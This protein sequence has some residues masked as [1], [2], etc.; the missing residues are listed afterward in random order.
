MDV[1]AVIR[2][3]AQVWAAGD[4]AVRS[5]ATADLVTVVAGVGGGYV[6][7]AGTVAVTVL[8]AHT[9]ASTGNRV[10]LRADGNVLLDARDKTG[11]VVM[12]ASIAGGFV[13]VGATVG[14]AVIDRDTQARVGDNSKVDGRALSGKGFLAGVLDGTYTDSAG[15]GSFTEFRGVAIQASSDL[16][17]TGVTASVGGGF[18]GVAGSVNVTTITVL[19]KAAIGAGVRVNENSAGTTV[20]GQ[21]VS[22]TAV[23]SSE[24]FALAGSV[25]GG[26]VGVGGGVNVGVLKVTV[27]SGTGG[28][29]VVKAKGN[30]GVHA[31]SAK[32]VTT[33]ALSV[34]G[35]FVGVAGSV[36]VW[37]IGTESTTTYDDGGEGPDRGSWSSTTTY[38]R[39][40]VVTFS[41][42]RYAAKEDSL[43]GGSDPSLN[44]A[45]WQGVQQNPMA[46]DQGNAVSDTDV[47]VSGQDGG[48]DRGAWTSASSYARN[49]VVTHNG[50][51]YVATRVI[52]AG[53]S[54][55]DT[56]GSG[57]VK[58]SGGY[59]TALK[60]T[61]GSTSTTWSPIVQYRKNDIV[62]VMV[63]GK[64][65]YYIALAD[66]YGADPLTSPALWARTSGADAATNGRIAAG[67]SLATAGIT[68][69]TPS[70][71]V[72]T[73][74]SGSGQPDGT[75]VLVAGTLEAGGGISV[76]AIE[77][78]EVYGLA[79]SV[80]GGVV[81]VGA[82]VL[83]LNV[84]SVTDA[85]VSGTGRLSAGGAISVNARTD[86]DMYALAAGG[87]GGVVGV[88]AQ[89]AVL[90]DDTR[91]RAHIDT[92]AQI[93]RAGGG[94]SIAATAVR[95]V[96][97]LVVVGTV[98]AGAAGAAV[99]VVEA[100][101]DTRAEIGN[102]AMGTDVVGNTG[103]VSGVSVAANA[104]VAPTATAYSA[105]LGGLALSGAVA[106]S[107]L[108]GV[109]R[110]ASGAHGPTGSGGVSVTATGTHDGVR[111]DSF[112]AAV[113]GV[114]GGLT[115][116][117]AIDDRSTEAE[118]TSTAGGTSSGSVNVTATA[119]NVAQAFAPSVSVGGVSLA[120]M[121]PTSR[122]S[123]HTS[124]RIAG[125]VA[126]STGIT[127]NAT[128]ANRATADAKIGSVAI[129]GLSG[130]FSTAEITSGAYI[131][132]SV[133]SASSLASSGALAVSA[134]TKT[135]DAT[136]A[137]AATATVGALSIGVISAGVMASDARVAG[138]VK[139][140]LDGTVTSS[141]GITVTATGGNTADA[142]NQVLSAGLFTGSGSMVRALV[143]STADVEA[144]SSSTTESLT[145][146]GAVS[147]T[148]TSSNRA[149][150]YTQ[151]AS[152]GLASLGVSVPTA[153]VGGGT[154][155]ALAASV[156]TSSGG[157]VVQATSRNLADADALTVAAGAFLG[158][159]FTKAD[160][161]VTADA[162]TD[163]LVAQSANITATGQTVL[164]SATSHNEANADTQQ[165]SAGAFSISGMATTARV[166]GA[167]TA[168]LAGDIHASESVT[169]RSRA[170]NVADSESFV[171]GVGLASGV[172]SY[173]AAE[174][175]AGAVTT[176]RTTSPS[177]VTST[178]AVLV[179]SAL[180]LD[181]NGDG[182][183]A[184]AKTYGASG[185]V[186][187]GAVLVTDAVV[188]APVR[189]TMDGDATAASTT[190]KA[191]G[192]N[193]AQA[194]TESLNIGAVSL[195][196]AGGNA[197]IASTA[198]VDATIGPLALLTLT[199][200]ARV[201]ATGGNKAVAVS[202]GATGGL[203]AAGVNLPQ[204]VVR[205]GVLAV[206]DGT[207]VGANLVNVTAVGVNKATAS[208]DLVAA[209]LF[210]GGGA[211]PS[212]V[213]GDDPATPAADEA[214]TVARLGGTGV[215]SSPAGTFTISAT[216]T[217]STVAT[218]G[219][220]T[221]GVVAVDVSQPTA[222]ASG[223]TR[224]QLF[225][226]VRTGSGPAA[227]AGATTVSVLASGTDTA[228]AS[229]R[230]V[231]GGV[232]R[233]GS[234]ASSAVVGSLVDVVVGRTGGST[235]IASDDIVVKA[236][237]T[238]DADS[239]THSAGGGAVNI[240]GF[241]SSASANPIVTTTLNSGTLLRAADQVT[242][243]AAHNE[244]Q[245]VMSDGTFDAGAA[246]DDV[247]DTIT[248]VNPHGLVT[249]SQVVYDA[250]G[251][252]N[253]GTYVTTG[254]SYTVIVPEGSTRTVLL[255]AAF[256]GSSYD[257]DGD[258]IVFPGAH[259]LRTDDMVVY[260]LGAGATATAGLV[261]GRSYRVRV[262]DS[263]RIRLLD[264]TDTALMAAFNAPLSVAATSIS[265]THV[266]VANS[267]Y[268]GAAVTYYAPPPVATFGSALVDA[269][270]TTL[271][272]N[273]VPERSGDSIVPQD[274]NRIYLAQHGLNTG[275]AVVY[276]AADPARRLTSAGVSLTQGGLFWVYRNNADQIQLATSYCNAVGPDDDACDLPDGGDAGTEPDPHPRVLMPLESVG[277][278]QHTLT[279]YQDQPLTDL[280]SGR[281]YFVV[282][283]DPST[284]F[285]RLAE[286]A[287]G[288]GL[289]LDTLGLTGG[290]H[291]FVVEGMNLTSTAGTG[292]QRLVLDIAPRSGVQQLVLGGL[293]N[294]I[295]APTGDRVV[296]ASSSGGGG[297]AINVT[298]ATATAKNTPTVRVD[299]SATVA[300]RDI[301]V[302]SNNVALV[303]AS[304]TNGGGG[305]ISVGDA[306]AFSYVNGSS[307]VNILSGAQLTGT[308]SVVIDGRSD[309]TASSAAETDSVGLGSGVD[310]DTA[311]TLNY[312]TVVT[313]DGTVTA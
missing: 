197:T 255:G 220:V 308:F 33:Y 214:E 50:V 235:V 187:S 136:S 134:T 196:G 96:D 306:D 102:V 154:K 271:N 126:G 244:L 274:N 169:V 206:L 212:A 13:G 38:N 18:V 299:V 27:Q 167:T 75:S 232:V 262:V 242:V 24:V 241:T 226:D 143:S 41:G 77:D 257:A 195:S 239:K 288:A 132:A 293:A 280:V 83:V 74:L 178:G 302:T 238:T 37:T 86:S 121:L 157:V 124:A 44:T 297:G 213:V 88:S 256:D 243:A 173:A 199:G 236:L 122:V 146:S 29:S 221:G 210:A 266:N 94:V 229:L 188:R 95:D 149:N 287:G 181:G 227:T 138:A 92:G 26:F 272:G 11:S 80:A 25:A 207:V 4:I 305:L 7:V 51:Q 106:V 141:S 72:S 224:A 217:N 180:V 193:L 20:A 78:L 133:D 66:S 12:V 290:Q 277:E 250:K 309:L 208:S 76:G 295:T 205:G 117:K 145:S 223:R 52:A 125:N 61:S 292:Q 303:N 186:I 301:A 3:D 225:G 114:A 189:A 162:T 179:D 158:G 142:K 47:V 123:G 251:F 46:T 192:G 151:S 81:G 160:A 53:G 57:W 139:A 97:A 278:T 110:A 263:A 90:N 216:A 300:G 190:V 258:M 265:A 172:G 153:E 159:A 279:R 168:E 54:S 281:T 58:R 248:F 118:L 211:S 284:G 204:A 182:N 43:V 42:K 310:T 40:D 91:Q 268:N 304:A 14:V 275:D 171:V 233:I 245:Q 71:L 164:I 113:G 35:G 9:H 130:A 85:G 63:A 289:Q 202:D 194:N 6:G 135:Y 311:A 60:G 231:G 276:R 148:A 144:T 68:G 10:V 55:P 249:G 19:T 65:H 152:G 64:W 183:R 174:I 237:G 155:A 260:H 252:A 70:S 98:G 259:N 104:N 228:S 286:S 219:T 93:H 307:K 111:A 176:A 222:T 15:F 166:G 129:T 240:S 282:G 17:V 137:N 109:T 163:A 313:V 273:L 283:R 56:A 103:T 253:L 30:I 101:G 23:D 264:I 269:K 267:F 21:G 32:D 31:L 48:V 234:A 140:R 82:S 201:E 175:T 218:A 34:G 99:A 165:V 45:K 298:S 1:D 285:F 312:E 5:S 203:V 170:Q 59:S 191:T 184:K 107:E 69:K 254:R 73:A 108:S 215:V 22:I 100:S 112:N 198:D 128:A 8:D 36:N 84:Q 209:G 67:T 119:I 39:G 116:V 105:S 296:T 246:V 200:A 131:D 161:L 247:A 115:I 261:D 291:R 150:A 87:A 147:F 2:D 294:L 185:G 230:S 177:A 270:T 16:L 127:V 62:R 120:A 28:G 49:D 89:V 79:G 156:T